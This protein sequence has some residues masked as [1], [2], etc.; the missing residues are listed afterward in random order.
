MSVSRCLLTAALFLV[1][2]AGPPAEQPALQA[3]PAVMDTALGH[4]VLRSFLLLAD[5]AA[6][7]LEPEPPDHEASRRDPGM[8]S[9]Y[10]MFFPDAYAIRALAV[11]YDLTGRDRYLHA[12]RTWSDR[13][14]RHQEKMVPSGA[15]YM[16]Y[17]RQPGATEGEWFVA[18]S[19]S[20]AMGVLAT[21]LRCPDPADR[22]RYVASAKAYADLVMEN[23]VRLS[24]GVTDGIWDKSDKEWWCS[25]ALFAAA[26]FELYNQTGTDAYRETALKAIDWLLDFE[27]GDTILYK[28]EDG[29]PTTIFYILEAYSAS[30]PHLAPGSERQRRVFRAFSQTVEWI[31]DSQTREGTWDY[32]PDNWG[33]KL[34]GLPC[35]TLIYLNRVPDAPARERL[36]ISR[37]G[38]VV[39]FESYARDSARRALDY[40]ASLDRGYDTLIQRNTFTLMSF[41]EALCPGELY[42]KTSAAFPYKRYSEDELSSLLA[43]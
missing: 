29:A 41:A 18:D 7:A 3:E 26:A 39:K 34:G 30:L 31:A 27:Y 35:H 10:H 38:K 20:I 8:R 6:R 19:G 33:V 43:R 5:L 32:N 28:F 4:K 16:N 36:V 13:M 12:C 40:F 11:A 9:D 1:A 2:C 37:A 24:G 23:Y 15:Y 42:Q 17:D 22:D 21:A 14:L 25:T